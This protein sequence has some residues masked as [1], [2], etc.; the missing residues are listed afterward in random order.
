L[1]DSYLG[2]KR[3]EAEVL[4]GMEDRERRLVLLAKY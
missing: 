3:G 2:V 1:V 4:R